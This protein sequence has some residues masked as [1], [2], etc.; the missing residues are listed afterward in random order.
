M[1]TK[2]ETFLALQPPRAADDDVTAQP[3]PAPT[4]VAWEVLPADE[5]R[6]ELESLSAWAQWLVD[7]YALPTSTVPACWFLHAGMREELGHLRTAWLFT[8]HPSMG[9]G[10]A[11]VDW[12]RHRDAALAR[13]THM[14]QVAGCGTSRGHQERGSHTRR[15]SDPALLAAHLA[16]EKTW[17]NEAASQAEL[18]AATVDGAL[19]ALADE[20]QRR[21]AE[22]S[23]GAAGA[24]ESEGISHLLG[25][26]AS[27]QQRVKIA[28]L[29]NRRL[30]ET[31]ADARQALAE[32][33]ADATLAPVARQG[34]DEDPSQTR[35]T[36]TVAND[37]TVTEAIGVWAAAFAAAAVGADEPTQRSGNVSAERHAAA[38]ALLDSAQ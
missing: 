29:T 37:S 23:A 38:R 24:D 5:Y 11:G 27:K 21:L 2:A 14:V 9:V 33:V 7:T 20:E 32:R 25:Q 16:D 6:R 4:V 8:R 10:P 30:D 18:H 13:L 15:A 1:D 35:T 36:A 34:A 17:R 3:V 31:L 12:D 28:A 26:V 19:R 22:P